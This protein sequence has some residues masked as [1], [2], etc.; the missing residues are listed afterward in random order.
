MVSKGALTMIRTVLAAIA[1]TAAVASAAA[2]PAAPVRP[3]AVP[4]AGQWAVVPVGDRTVSYC[5]MGLRSDEAAPLPGRPQ[6]M[7]GADD[8]FAILRVRAAEWSFGAGGDVAVTLVNSEGAE[9]RPQAV[10]RGTDLIDVAF[11]TD[12][13]QVAELARSSHLDI[14]AEG[15]IVRLPLLGLADVLPAY[16]DCLANVGKPAMQRHA[17]AVATIR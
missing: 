3:L 17:A 9:H 13:R 4:A 7:I 2:Q 10:V 12:P 11:G 14:R 16:R 1:A 8:R 6:F 5:A 15:T